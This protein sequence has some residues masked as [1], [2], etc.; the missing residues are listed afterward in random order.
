M[1]GR[2]SLKFIRLNLEE[3]HRVMVKGFRIMAAAS[4]YQWSMT[5]Y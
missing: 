4:G 2:F 3:M 1:R 5:R